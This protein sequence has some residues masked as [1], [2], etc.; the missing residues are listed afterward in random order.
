MNHK[1]NKGFISILI[2]FALV[3]MGLYSVV[4]I[5]ITA[6]MQ[7]QTNQVLL[8][9]KN[10]NLRQSAAA[11]VESRGGIKGAVAVE[12]DEDVFRNCSINI[13][14]DSNSIM[15]DTDCSNGRQKVSGSYKVRVGK[16]L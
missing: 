1:K 12:L 4:L 14:G 2:V 6:N 10:F 5:G 11:F 3:I 8:D 13:T 9:A 15:I 16:R 7:H